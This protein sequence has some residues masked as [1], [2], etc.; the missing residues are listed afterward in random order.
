[1]GHDVSF[2]LKKG[3]VVGFLGPNGASFVMDKHFLNT[4]GGKSNLKM[5]LT[6]LFRT[7]TQL[8]F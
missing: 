5:S 1:M 2:S 6:F 3:E 8:S 7:K 4:N